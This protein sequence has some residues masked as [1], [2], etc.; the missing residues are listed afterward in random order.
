MD[1]CRRRRG[2]ARRAWSAGALG[3]IVLVLGGCATNPVTGQSQFTLYTEAEE[4][5]LGLQAN[6][7]ML[8]NYGEYTEDP[9]LSA[10]VSQLG[11]AMAAQSERPDLPWAFRILDDEAINALALPGGQIYVTRGLLAYLG[12]ESELAGVLG[13][14]IGHVTARHSIHGLSRD[15]ALSVAL[16]AGLVLLDE[17]DAEPVAALGLELLFLKF[18]RNQERQAD[19]LAV[20]YA[21]RVGLDP[22]GTV[23]ALRILAQV[24]AAEG[25]GGFPTWL[26]THPD[27]DR[28]W[29]RLAE[30][31]GLAPV[32]DAAALVAD[33]QR[34]VS[35]LDGLVV[36][37]DPRNGVVEGQVYTQVRDGF[38]IAFPPGWT[39]ERDGRSVVAA[40]PGDDAAVLLQHGPEASVQEAEAALVGEEGVTTGRPWNESLGGLPTRLIGFDTSLDGTE[41]RGYV[42]FVPLGGSVLKVIALSETARFPSLQNPLYG[43]IRSLRKLGAREAAAARPERLRV[44]RLDRPARLRDLAPGATAA[45]LERLALLND[46][47]AGAADLPLAAGRWVKLRVAP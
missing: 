42:A 22:Y 47:D 12:R 46:L 1:L 4:I 20:R 31:N 8:Q 3:L 18:S 40:S 41:V 17:E 45:E 13:H 33:R 2:A 44:V 7:E 34:Y 29:H 6:R 36:G 5:E 39:I 30:E 15:L 11:L 16:E 27:P 32:T 28:R 19:G 26:S 38:Q 10:Y 43:T 23:D 35:R 14:E 24:S 37:E 9:Q 25:E 21:P